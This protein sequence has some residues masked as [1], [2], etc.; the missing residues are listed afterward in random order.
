LLDRLNTLAYIDEK[1][2]RAPSYLFYRRIVDQTGQVL[3]Q[4][5][6]AAPFSATPAKLACLAF[7]LAAVGIYYVQH[8]VRPFDNLDASSLVSEPKKPAEFDM[9]PIKNVTETSEK[10][11]W[12]E[13]R[14]VDP[15]HDVKLTKVDVLPLQIEMAASSPLQN[16]AWITSVNGAPEV[17]HD[18]AAPTDPSYA[19]YQPLIYLDELQVTDWDVISYYARAQAGDPVTDYASKINFI[20]IRPFREDI[21]KLTGGKDGKNANMRYQLL[22]EL[23]GLIQQQISVLQETH[24]HQQISYDTDELRRQD[25]H[26]LSA[27]ERD[28]AKATDHTFAKIAAQ[29]ENTDVGDILDHLSQAGEH[30]NGAADSLDKE[31]VPEGKQQEESSLSQLIAT[32]KAFKKALSDDPNAFGGSGGDAVA[33]DMTPTAKD[34]LKALTNVSEMRDENK[35]GLQELHRIAQE[36]RAMADNFSPQTMTHVQPQQTKLADDLNQLLQRNPD[37]F[38]GAE[39]QSAAAQEAASS[40]SQSMISGNTGRA[41]WDAGR[42]ADSLAD[43]EK[44]VSQNYAS[45]QLSQ[46]YAM[47]KTIDENIRQLAREQAKPGSTSSEDAQALAEAARRATSTLKEIN[48]GLPSGAFGPQLSQSLSPE[49]QQALNQALDRF[50]QAQPGAQRGA[51]AAPAQ[52]ELEK[53]SQAFDQSR[54]AINQ[55]VAKQDALGTA[56]GDSLD[57]ATQ[58]LQSLLAAQQGSHAPSAAD[59]AKAENQ[60]LHDVQVGLDQEKAGDTAKAAVLTDTE[61]LLKSREKG[62]QGD[63][64]KLQRLLDDIESVRIEMNDVGVVKADLNTT[65]IDPS[66]FPPAYRERIKTYYE[67]LSAQP[68]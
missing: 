25:G 5:P 4:E 37:L 26:K 61:S 16:P 56:P 14:I 43:L 18:L 62:L 22:N 28:L 46:A 3:Q 36:Q 31:A 23:S 10:K 17:G 50:T 66:K 1:P 30:M 15:G 54:P 21:L 19:V 64:T 29:G 2:T 52:G 60:I 39:S 47:K 8:A 49:N 51:A 27:A 11:V 34:S 13:V 57:Q 20:E 53:V 38:K 33:D 44:T 6:A 12:G 9:A 59:E 32:R 67:Q 41:A 55:Q 24:Q 42:A 40:A 45:K 48:D 63:P 35:A 65:M 58:E 68:Q 7:A